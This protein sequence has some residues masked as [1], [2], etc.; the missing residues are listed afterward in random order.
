M[1]DVD[2]QL[3]HL[4]L[5]HFQFTLIHGPNIPG[6][7][8]ILLFIAWDFTGTSTAKHHFCLAQPAILTGAISNHLPLFLSS[9]LG[10]FQPWGLI[11][12]C[13]IFFPSHTICGVLQ[14]K[15]WSGLPFPPPVDQILSEFF[16]MTCPSCVALHCMTQ[17]SLSYT[18]PLAT[19]RLWSMKRRS[20]YRVPK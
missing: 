8:E 17:D 16:S 12:Q 15:Y 20:E 18:S 9:I 6:S 5:D 3:C 11:F 10:T 2:V 7:Y 13:H 1:V 19:T 14:E 4:L